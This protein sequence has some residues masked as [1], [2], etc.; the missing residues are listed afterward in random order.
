MRNYCLTA[1]YFILSLMVYVAGN[2]AENIPGEA[3][4][5]RNVIV[6]LATGL[7]TQQYDLLEA[8]CRHEGKT[9]ALG[10]MSR[11]GM[12]H[13]SIEGAAIPDT[14]GAASTLATG[15][16]CRPGVLSA[17]G[18]GQPLET[19]LEQAMKQ[20]R[21]SALITLGDLSR[22][23]LGAFA[24]HT[25]QKS[26]AAQR[27]SLLVNSGASVLVGADIQLFRR[28][29]NS[30][31]E[32]LLESLQNS[33]YD[34]ID[35]SREQLLRQQRLPVAGFF[36]HRYRADLKYFKQEPRQD[37]ILFKVW[38]LLNQN[39]G[40]FFMVVETQ[41]LDDSCRLGDIAG[42]VYELQQ[43][44][45]AVA[46]GQR[47]AQSNPDTLLLV[48]SPHE[49]GN[50]LMIE[51]WMPNLLEKYKT[52]RCSPRYA[53]DFL[54]EQPTPL[55]AMKVF[56]DKVGIEALEQPEL[57]RIKGIPMGEPRMQVIADIITHHVNGGQFLQSTP[58]GRRT[59]F[60]VKGPGEDL[61]PGEIDNTDVASLL[62]QAMGIAEESSQ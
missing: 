26:D 59:P 31:G 10:Q 8:V 42:L 14:E 61:W 3:T 54:E 2:A 6:Y 15:V 39:P 41:G 48:V 11:T 5:A 45:E 34:I 28:T 35:G 1:L 46:A 43:L 49:T 53:E 62:R 52:I 16:K 21:L 7:G 23:G 19:I 36:Q 44:D 29:K 60:F 24:T 12:M 37:Q 55:E 40:G 57:A 18:E 4:Q 27:A 22:G 33:G 47:F 17:T 58:S 20:G 9:S 25:L 51:D 56:R 50:F 38:S 13:V 32:S 30:S